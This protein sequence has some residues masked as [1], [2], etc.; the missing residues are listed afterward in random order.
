[1]IMTGLLFGVGV[2]GNVLLKQGFDPDLFLPPGTYLTTWLSLQKEYFPNNGKDGTICFS[3]TSLPEELEKIE[4]LVFDLKSNSK[5]IQ[6]VA[7]WTTEYKKFVYD[8]K[9]VDPGVS[10]A[11]LNQSAFRKTLTQ[12]LFSPPGAPHKGAFQFKSELECGIEAPEI[13]LFQ[14]FYRHKLFSGPEEHVP[15]MNA[16]KDAVAGSNVSGRV[17]PISSSYVGWETDDVL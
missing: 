4:D 1:M 9:L 13:L 17:F 8:I 6:N 11:S 15:A 7:S 16:V 3:N 14:L 5:I 10:I 2:W 12:F